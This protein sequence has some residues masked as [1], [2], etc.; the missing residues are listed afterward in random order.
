M[1]TEE[2][3][4][5]RNTSSPFFKAFFPPNP[6]HISKEVITMNASHMISPHVAETPNK[7]AIIFGDRRISYAGSMSWPRV[8][9]PTRY[10][11]R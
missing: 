11:W 10:L 2:G 6:Y 1:L 3:W 5:A 9:P 7:T 4:E 8:W